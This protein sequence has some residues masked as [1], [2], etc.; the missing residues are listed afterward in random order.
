MRLY[1]GE[2]NDPSRKD[3]VQL[4]RDLDGFLNKLVEEKSAS[5]LFHED[6]LIQR[7][8]THCIFMTCERIFDRA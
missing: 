6:S 4:A 3:C 1:T 7:S 5:R 8:D 2:E